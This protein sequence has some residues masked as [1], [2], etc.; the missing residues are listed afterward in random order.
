MQTDINTFNAHFL[1]PVFLFYFL[2]KCFSRIILNYL[3]LISY[4]PI[5][6]MQNLKTSNNKLAFSNVCLD[7]YV[8]LTNMYTVYLL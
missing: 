8:S 1:L 3:F 5:N 2:M 4:N 7:F 6:I